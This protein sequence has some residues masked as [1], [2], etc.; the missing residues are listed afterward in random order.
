MKVGKE[1]GNG[2]GKRFCLGR[3]A[4]DANADDVLLNCAL[5]NCTLIN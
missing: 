3:W 2:D 5:E 1:G 4:S